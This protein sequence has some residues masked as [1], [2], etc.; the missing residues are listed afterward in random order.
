MPRTRPAYP[1]VCHRQMV[2]LV[3]AGRDPTDL[4]REFE[5]A[6][7]TIQNWVVE[8][9]RREGRRETKR[10]TA[11]PGLTAAE[12]DELV[13]LRRKNRQL[14]SARE[15][16]V[17]AATFSRAR[18][19]GPA[20]GVFRFMSANRADLPIAAMARVLGV[21]KA[22]YYA[23]A[24]REPSA[25]ATADAALLKRI[26]ILH[27]GSPRHTVRRASTLICTS[28]ASGIFANASLG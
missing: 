16:K 14:K 12:R 19:R 21:S 27:L 17:S 11:D 26:R 24:K 25:R 4:A 18:V 7:Q 22:G 23:W 1:A 20:V 28:R 6:R 15:P 8:A 13:R 2:A 10:S 9:D 5:P 3:R